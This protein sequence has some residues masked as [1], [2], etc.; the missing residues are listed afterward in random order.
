MPSLNGDWKGKKMTPDINWMKNNYD[1]ANK[2][3]FDGKLGDCNFTLSTRPAKHIGR[4]TI[5]KAYR[6]K[7]KGRIYSRFYRRP[8][9]REDFVRYAEPTI[10]LNLAYETTE[11]EWF[12][13][14][15]HE[16]CHYATCMD[17]FSPKQWHG[18]EFRALAKMIDK[19]S[20]G[21]VKISTYTTG[22]E[23]ISKSTEDRIAKQREY[24][25]RSIARKAKLIVKK[26]HGEE[27]CVI[28]SSNMENF[29]ANC[30]YNGGD[31]PYVSNNFELKLILINNGYDI[32]KESYSEAG[33][34]Y[35][36]I[37][38]NMLKICGV[39]SV[40]ELL[41]KYNFV[42]M[43]NSMSQSIYDDY[44]DC[45]IEDDESGYYGSLSQWVKENLKESN[46]LHGRMITESMDKEITEK[47]RVFL[48]SVSDLTY[49]IATAQGRKDLIECLEDCDLKK[50]EIQSLIR[51]G[52]KFTGELETLRGLQNDLDWYK[53]DSVYKDYFDIEE[54]IYFVVSGLLARNQ[55]DFAK[56]IA[57]RLKWLSENPERYLWY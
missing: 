2:L 15:V 26:W 13:T 43:S 5:P 54:T 25:N 17:G 31:N 12:N 42:R 3:F 53:D 6:D 30:K 50:W 14:L 1:K 55:I 41:N 33:G 49:K 21:T 35:N 56:E 52:L 34:V 47:E 4:F 44:G 19:K 32:D 8:L 7:T 11:E 20:N 38:E 45:Y 27:Y 24:R 36:V 22:H 10:D 51:D 29:G 9:T 46:R 16:M 37:D 39:S 28:I 40:K 57:E 48:N 18:K 23:K